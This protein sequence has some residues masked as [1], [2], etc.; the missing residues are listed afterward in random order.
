MVDV[1]PIFVVHVSNLLHHNNVGITY[2][3]TS[4]FKMEPVRF[5][6][7]Y[8]VAIL[9]S[10]VIITKTPFVTALAH[11]IVGMKTKPQTLRE[12]KLVSVHTK[13][14]REVD[15]IF[16]KQPLD[17]R[18][19]GSNPLRPLGP[20]GYFGLPMMN[21]SRPPLPTNMPYRRPLN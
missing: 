11:I 12:T 9:Y 5:V 21:P 13:M 20:L 4:N 18:R 15:K 17:P 10:M 14:P 8:Y 1:I 6:P 16:V 19:R 3:R 2:P 7:L